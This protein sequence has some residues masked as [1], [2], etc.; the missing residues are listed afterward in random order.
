MTRNKCRFGVVSGD[1]RRSSPWSVWS[2]GNDVYVSPRTQGGNF[3]ISLHQSGRW[4]LTFDAA[5]ADRMNK[6]G[7]WAGDRCIERLS[8]PPE[9]ARGFTRAARIYFPES[10]LREFSAGWEDAQ[11][12]VHI[13]AP[14]QCGLRVVDLIFTTS[15][16]RYSDADCPLQASLAAK[17]IDHWALANGETL[18]LVHFE[19]ASDRGL[20]GE[21][22]GF[23]RN[24][25]R[26]KKI[27]RGRALKP[28]DD[29]GRIMVSGINEQGWFCVI[30]AAA[31]GS[32]VN[33]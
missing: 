32:A 19:F 18:W 14:P 22:E 1:S 28:L 3:K 2:Q 20:E 8:R 9:H 31:H 33:N 17:K 29:S 21:A 23:R 7:V 16:S 25:D 6:L 11:K 26:A 12:I 24:F 30:D 4:R 5:Y 13:A 10:E 15:R 27:R